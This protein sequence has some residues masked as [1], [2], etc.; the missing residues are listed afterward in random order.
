MGRVV[1]IEEQ[2]RLDA[3]PAPSLMSEPGPCPARIDVAWFLD[4][5]L[6][7]LGRV[8]FWHDAG[9]AKEAEEPAAEPRSARHGES[10]EVVAR[11]SAVDALTADFGIVASPDRRG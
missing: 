2:R 4:E 1:A 3:G 8:L 6:Q 9:M 7:P 10:R 5:H 11:K